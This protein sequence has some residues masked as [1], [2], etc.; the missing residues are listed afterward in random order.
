MTPT[1]PNGPF[2]FRGLNRSSAIVDVL[3]SAMRD[4]AITSVLHR[5]FHRAAVYEDG[6]SP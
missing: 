6:L 4:N 2:D 5:A 3:A 1:A